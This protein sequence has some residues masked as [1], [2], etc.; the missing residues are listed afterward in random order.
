MRLE[1]VPQVTI[2]QP[3]QISTAASTQP[4]TG[5]GAGRHV[6]GRQ[7]RRTRCR[8]RSPSTIRR[9]SSSRK[10]W[11]RSRS[12]PR[13]RRERNTTAR[14][15]SAAA[16]CAARA[17]RRTAKAARPSGLPIWRRREARQQ[18][19]Q[20]GRAGTEQLVEVTQGLTAL[21]KLIVA[22]ARTCGRR[23]HSRHGRRSP[24]RRHIRRPSRVA[25]DGC[26]SRTGNR[27]TK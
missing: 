4:L 5:R 9:R 24:P 8:S 10:C 18:S 17:G 11:R 3:V 20:L 2:G 16:A 19:V 25:D 12:S 1:D 14:A 22:A 23:A 6:A 21:D 26:V 27:I 7:S 15:R 13:A